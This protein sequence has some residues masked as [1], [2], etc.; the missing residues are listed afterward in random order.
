MR[1]QLQEVEPGRNNVIGRWPGKK[2]TPTLLFSG[3]FDTST[4][5]REAE[6]WGGDYNSEDFGG[7]Q[8]RAAVA[9]GW[10]ERSRCVKHE[11]SVCRLLGRYTGAAARGCGAR[12][13]HPYCRRRRRDRKRHQSTNSREQR[14]TRGGKAGSRYMVTHGVTAD[15]AIIGEP[16]GM[17]LQIG[18]TSYCFAKITVYG[19]SQHTWCKEFGMGPI[20]KK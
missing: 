15:F 11:G 16:T 6:A 13:R 12:W 18:E 9:N 20:E 1:V 4:T 19:K 8:I 14:I 3:H 17:R 10:I 2:G 5:G 7:G